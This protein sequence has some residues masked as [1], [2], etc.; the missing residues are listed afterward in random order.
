MR[1]VLHLQPMPAMAGGIGAI[2]ALRDNALKA[3]VTGDLEQHVAKYVTPRL[4]K[5]AMLGLIDHREFPCEA[6][7]VS[8]H[9]RS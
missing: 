7:S 9:A 1:T 8:T 5:W 3:R 4:Q 6:Q 2:T